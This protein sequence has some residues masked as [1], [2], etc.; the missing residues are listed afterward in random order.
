LF[1]ALSLIGMLYDDVCRVYWQRNLYGMC[2]AMACI[3]FLIESR[4]LHA[5]GKDRWEVVHAAALKPA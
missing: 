3:Y 1:E 5:I 4:A 2:I